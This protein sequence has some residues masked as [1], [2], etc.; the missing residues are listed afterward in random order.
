MHAGTHPAFYL[1]RRTGPSSQG[2]GLRRLPRRA[3]PRCTSLRTTCASSTSWRGPSSHRATCGPATSCRCARGCPR[4]RSTPCPAA[5][6]CALCHVPV[7]SPGGGGPAHGD[8]CRPDAWAPR[9]AAAH[10][11]APAP[12]RRFWTRSR[13]TTATEPPTSAPARPGPAAAP[14]QPCRASGTMAAAAVPA[15]ARPHLLPQ[16]VPWG[17]VRLVAKAQ[18]GPAKLP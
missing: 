18:T 6:A 13:R 8:A 16:V 12:C 15:G 7:G 1:F 10:L 5:A 11:L 17:C 4:P 3:A 2:P 9:R 14:V